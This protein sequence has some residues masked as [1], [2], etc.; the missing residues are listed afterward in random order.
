MSFK[1]EPERDTYTTEVSDNEIAR[2]LEVLHEP[3]DV[4][5]IR[6]PKTAPPRSTWEST[7]SG[8]FDNAEE[9]AKQLAHF[10]RIGGQ[11]PAVFVTVNPCRTDLL[12]RCANAVQD[13]ARNTTRDDEINRRRW[14]FIDLDVCRP[15]GTSSTNEEL[16]RAEARAYDIMSWLAIKGFPEPLLVMSGNGFHIYYRVDLPADDDGLIQRFL[17]ALGDRFDDDFVKIDRGVY[18]AGQITKVAGTMVRKGDHIVGRSDMPDRP[19]R[20]A[21]WMNP[22]CTP[23]LVG[24]ELLQRLADEAPTPPPAAERLTGNAV[25]N[26][27]LPQLPPITRRCAFVKHCFDDAETLPEPEWYAALGIVGRCEDGTA[28]AHRMSAPH[29]DY[30]PEAT[31]R[32]LVQALEKAG[33][34]TCAN[35]QQTFGFAACADCAHRDTITSPI[36]LGHRQDD[37]DAED[38][39]YEIDL[40]VPLD[41]ARNFV[42]AKYQH[43][44]MTTLIRLRGEY[45]AWNQ[46]KWKTIEHEGIRATLYDFLENCYRIEVVTIDGKIERIR[47]GTPPD[48][49]LVGHVEDPLRAVVR[50]DQ[51]LEAPCWLADHEGDPDPLSLVVCRNGALDIES[52]RLLPHSPR[53]FSTNALDVEYDAN[54]PRPERWRAFLRELWPDDEE[55]VQLLQEWCGL[56]LTADTSFQKMLALVGP[57][58][59][60]KGTIARV[61]TELVGRENTTGPTLS[62]FAANFGMQ[63]CINARLAVIPDARMPGRNDQVQILE[64]LLSIVGE[65]GIQIDRKYK[66]PWFGRL[67]TRL[68][69]VTNELPAF[70]DSSGALAARVLLLQTT[71][72]FLGKEDPQL[73]SRLLAELPGI[74]N[75]AIEGWRRLQARGYFVQPKS[76]LELLD[77]LRELHSP[78]QTFVAERC[79]LGADQGVDRKVL[80]NAW[81]LWCGDNGRDHPGTQA[82]FNRRLRACCSTIRKGHPRASDGT[83][84]RIWHGIGLRNSAWGAYSKIPPIPS[85]PSRSPSADESVIKHE[86]HED[87]DGPLRVAS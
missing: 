41:V 25:G 52:G 4:F 77:E 24:T 50:Q 2:F 55:S 1:S 42:Q 58:R 53:L 29:P 18:N 83:R 12:A 82:E 36:Q 79:E 72:S 26:V 61:M 23:Q 14:L 71:K 57:T 20:R 17:H 35:I 60:G 66:A 21:R 30:S 31:D 51:D 28:E 19:H 75:W 34:R 11:F 8:Y 76:S 3:G 86:A 64:R 16:A 10:E 38:D 48:A 70:A 63:V 45:H 33:P 67:K 39:P 81:K 7:W 80:Y 78:V 65:D 15:S 73:T 44:D 74:L 46:I 47:V 87:S 49:A 56:C 32:K 85:Q 5:E 54:A 68:M 22:D 37:E 13:N 43:H 27:V 62:A 69:I 59:S 9:A 6:M 40:N 84:P